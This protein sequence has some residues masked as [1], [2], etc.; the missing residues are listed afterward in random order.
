MKRILFVDD[1]PMI[2]AGL[3]NLLRKQRSKWEM[4]FV[5]NGQAALDMLEKSAF[6]VIVSDMRMPKMD[7][8]ALLKQV[9]SKYPNVVRIV[10][11]GHAELE[12][13]LKSVSIAHQF[14]NK[15]CDASTLQSVVEGPAGYKL[16]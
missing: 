1:E 10:L 6:D 3:Q 5:E 15:P 2:L 9:Q 8:A 14:L 11:S 16:C 7:G 4:F 12:T 13:A